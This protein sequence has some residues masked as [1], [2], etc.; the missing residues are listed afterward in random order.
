MDKVRL[1]IIGVGNIGTSHVKRI[2]GGTTPNVSLSAICD[3]DP[4]KLDKIKEICGEVPTFTDASELI[5]SGMVDA[6]LIAVPH[7][8]HPPIAIEAFSHG[9]HVLCEKP[10]GVYTKQVLEMN[11]AAKKSGK[12]FGIMYNQ[13]TNPVYAKLRDMIQ[14][15]ML[16]HIK[17]INWTVTNWYRPQAY[18]SSATWRST[19][20]GEGGGTLINQNPH[21]IDLWQWMFGMPDKIYADCSFGKYYDIEVEDEVMA[22]MKYDS[23]TTG[24][25]VTSIGEAPGTNRLE[26]ACD[27]G[28]IVVEDNTMTFWRNVESEREFNAKNTAPFGRPEAWKCEIPLPAGSGE[29]HTG[30]I[31]DFASAILTDSP[32]LAPG[33][34]GILGLTISNAMH[35][36]TWTGDWVKLSDFPHDAFYEILQEK[37]R[38]ST[39]KKEIKETAVQDTS[40]TY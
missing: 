12:V 35:Y 4:K 9:L 7:Y 19:W 13:R 24:V 15:G 40:G 27:M 8:M 26:V 37:I 18:H 21:Q 25:Y 3:I 22:Y 20:E 11:E 36:S 10:A 6:I 14:S 32:L 17:R 16:G 33:E 5:A 34:E 23:G 30:I 31:N 28:K 29:Q 2:V 38:N 1:G 39:V